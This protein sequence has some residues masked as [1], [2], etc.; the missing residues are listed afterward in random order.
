MDVYDW[1]ALTSTIRFPRR[2]TVHLG[3]CASQRTVDNRTALVPFR[4][5][6]VPNISHDL[7]RFQSL[8]SSF[9]PEKFGVYPKDRAILR[10]IHGLRLYTH[11]RTVVFICIFQNIFLF[12]IIFYQK[13]Y[14]LY[15][16]K[17]WIF[18]TI[19]NNKIIIFC[20]C[21]I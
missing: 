4:S 16:K 15:I 2:S 19:L 7:P 18:Y 12:L 8:H 17:I 9:Q 3:G 21:D 10:T 13:F 20:M 14:N 1:I 6:C 5:P 11:F